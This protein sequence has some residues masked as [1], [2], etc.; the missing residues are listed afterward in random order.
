MRIYFDTEFCGLWDPTPISI[1]F[2][3]ETG[4]E[5]Y[6]EVFHEDERRGEFVNEVIVPLLDGD[7]LHSTFAASRSISAWIDRLEQAHGSIELVC[8]FIGDYWILTRMM[9]H[10]LRVT[11]RCARHA[12]TEA[13]FKSH[14]ELRQH[15]AL[16]DARALRY[17]NP[18]LQVE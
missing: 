6:L 16:D 14:P 4:E 15:N 8:D 7:N 3:A 17:L 9:E 12:Q 1:G 2:A 18:V 13:V 10:N 11:P 5:L